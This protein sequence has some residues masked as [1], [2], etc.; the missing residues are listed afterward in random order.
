MRSPAQSRLSDGEGKSYGGVNPLLNNI[1]A[2]C[3]FSW[4]NFFVSSRLGGKN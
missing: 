1:C 2:F 4:P 3:A